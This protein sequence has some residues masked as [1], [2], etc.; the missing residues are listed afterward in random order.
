MKNA[1]LGK[2]NFIKNIK[3]KLLIDALPLVFMFAFLIYMLASYM[4]SD[5]SDSPLN[6][7]FYLIQILC[8]GILLRE[9]S[10]AVAITTFS[11][12]FIVISF[13]AYISLATKMFG[14]Q[15]FPGDELN[16]LPDRYLVYSSGPNVWPRWIMFALMVI[17]WKSLFMGMRRKYE[18]A[19]LILAP[20]LV[21][22]LVL[23]GSR[24][25]YLAFTVS[26]AILLIVAKQARYLNSLMIKNFRFQFLLGILLAV[27]LEVQLSFPATKMFI[28]RVF[29]LTLNQKSG[30]GRRDFLSSGL[31]I[32]SN[33]KIFGAGEGSYSQ[34]SGLDYPHNIFVEILA[35]GGIVG[36]V[37]LVLILLSITRLYLHSRES[38]KWNFSAN[39]LV[40]TLIVGLLVLQ[41]FSGSI[42]DARFLFL[43]AP[44]LKKGELVALAHTPKKN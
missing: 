24:G 27:L 19:L 33:N 18:L 7:Y 28:F 22:L 29:D 17:L 9:I 32:Y 6:Q 40:F 44:L 10:R 42:V 15:V 36:F 2:V 30:S 37:L 16:G 38:S 41:Q 20:S 13:I 5:F 34:I 39:T 3:Y 35:E 4:W 1:P 12:F 43:L 14:I 8:S 23:S 26:C 25:I 31:E 11:V 21:W